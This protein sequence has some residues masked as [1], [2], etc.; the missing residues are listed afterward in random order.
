MKSGFLAGI[1][2]VALSVASALP[3]AAQAQSGELPVCNEGSLWSVAVTTETDA[4][5]TLSL[6]F[7][8]TPDGWLLVGVSYCS[9]TGNCS[10]D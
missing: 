5:G 9:V 8:C 7:L 3:G 10:S 2:A 4:L 1:L 6:T